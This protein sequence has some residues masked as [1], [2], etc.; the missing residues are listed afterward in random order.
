MKQGK[1]SLKPETESKAA[2]GKYCNS[3]LYFLWKEIRATS[4]ITFK[5]VSV[6]EK[7]CPVYISAVYISV[8]HWLGKL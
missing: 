3:Y 6:I 1:T 7:I 8:D 2:V 5:A 4:V